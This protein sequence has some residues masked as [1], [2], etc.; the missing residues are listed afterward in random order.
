MN[1]VAVKGV[2]N[3]PFSPRKKI[4]PN[5]VFGTLAFVVTEVMFFVALLSAYQVIK[6]RFGSWA[7]PQGVTLFVV[8]TVVNLIILIVSGIFLYLSGRAKKAGSE[9]RVYKGHYL[10]AIVLGT[11]FVLVQGWEWSQLFSAGLGFR[12][13]IFG[14]IFY[15]IIGLHAL[16]A[17]SAIVLM[18]LQ[19]RKVR[20][21]TVLLENIQAMQVYWYFIVG[22]WPIL[23]FNLYFP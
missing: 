13:E 15:L 2:A 22:V 20:S 21:G 9:L 8:Q 7:P 10:R 4:L 6:A 19:F 17:V 18:L 3:A 16:H 14:S 11:V 12:N 5:S 1:T 23:Y